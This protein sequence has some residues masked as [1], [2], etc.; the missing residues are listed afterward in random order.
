[1]N[2]Q[3]DH[4]F[5]YDVTKLLDLV[6]MGRVAVDLYA[7]QVGASLKDVQS[8]R[9]Y[10]GGCAGNI[11]VG[12]APLNLKISMLSCVGA[13]AMGQFLLEKLKEEGIDLTGLQTS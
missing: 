6:S 2:T 3:R 12:S 7:E 11:A 1:M 5:E 9:K 8:F 10:L 13:D 4:Y